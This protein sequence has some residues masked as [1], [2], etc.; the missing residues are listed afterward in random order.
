M[1]PVWVK[2]TWNAVTYDRFFGF[3][4]E[5]PQTWTIGPE[6]DAYVD[7]EAIDG[8]EVLNLPKVSIDRPVEGTGARIEAILDLI[9]WPASLRDID[10]GDSQ[11]QAVT[12]AGASP[13]AHIQDV[14]ASEGGLFFMSAGGVATFFSRTHA[15]LLD[16]ANDTWGDALGEKA[17]ESL[18]T[19]YDQSTLWNEVT[20]TAPNLADQ[21]VADIASQALFSGPLGTLAPR[22]LTV[23]T[24]LTTEAEML[25]RANFILGQFSMPKQR[26]ATL[27]LEGRGDDTQWPRILMHELHDRVLA[28]KRPP[29]GGLIDQPSLV[30]GITEEIWAQHWKTTW[31][32]SSTSYQQGQWVL[33]DPVLSLLGETT[34]LV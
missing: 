9:Q 34:S 16:E 10:L 4:Q 18:E 21:T 29:G 8:F 15:V 6:P 7:L 26:I 19:S 22:S 11:V 25:E 1:T 14:A 3:V 5:W 27:A 30:E 20:V 23:P 13:L 32:L 31:A 17:Y 28:R 33:G 24:L 12:L 2:G